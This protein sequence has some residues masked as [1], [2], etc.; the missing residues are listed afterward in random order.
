MGRLIFFFWF[1]AGDSKKKVE[2][3][4]AAQADVALATVGSD[5]DRAA[6]VTESKLDP[7][8]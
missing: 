4:D 6:E 8:E 7:V 2:P 5:S 1:L 3:D